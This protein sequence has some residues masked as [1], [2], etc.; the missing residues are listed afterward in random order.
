MIGAY[1]GYLAHFGRRGPALG[2]PMGEIDPARHP[3]GSLVGP[4]G[5]GAGAYLGWAAQIASM[6]PLRPKFEELSWGGPMGGGFGSKP[7]GGVAPDLTSTPLYFPPFNLGQRR[8][9]T[10]FGKILEPALSGWL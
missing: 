8:A 10:S 2:V 9:A 3:I 1:N 6:D 7:H 5:L 4:M